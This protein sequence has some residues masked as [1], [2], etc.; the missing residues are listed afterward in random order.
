M[1]H[2]SAQSADSLFGRCRAARE[3]AGG[4]CAPSERQ[5]TIVHAVLPFVTCKRGDSSRDRTSHRPAAAHRYT[6]PFTHTNRE[7]DEDSQADE[8]AKTHVHPEVGK[9]LIGNSEKKH[10]YLCEMPLDE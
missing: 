10:R 5:S 8:D 9:D 7:T 3:S 1:R 4:R 6:H 2:E